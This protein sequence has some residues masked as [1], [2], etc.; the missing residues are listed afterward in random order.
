ML[1]SYCALV[2]V[3]RSAELAECC[4]DE[5][6]DEDG[7]VDED[8]A[9]ELDTRPPR[10]SLSLAEDARVDV[11]VAVR[12]VR[13]SEDEDGDEDVEWNGDEDE[14]GDEDDCWALVVET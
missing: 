4:V 13:C 14:V 6:S 10:V 7:W 3:S 5:L 8:A 1:V 12:V 9:A 2:V 11:T